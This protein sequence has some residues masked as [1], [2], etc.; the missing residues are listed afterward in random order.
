MAITSA[1]FAVIG[2]GVSI[3]QQRKASKAA[4]TADKLKNRQNDL[5]N[6][7]R[8][9]KAVEDAKIARANA[10]ASAGAAGVQ[11]SSPLQGALGSADTQLAS[12]VGFAQQT[13]GANAQANRLIAGANRDLN[14]A[15]TFQAIGQLPQQFGFGSVADAGRQI[16]KRR[17]AQTTQS[18]TN[19]TGF[20]LF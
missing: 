14:R 18:N 5:E 15:S 19:P 11:D 6:K 16:A 2:T 8:I 3:S 13:A 20:G 1:I 4:D 17:N 9:N 12:N 7:R 10:L